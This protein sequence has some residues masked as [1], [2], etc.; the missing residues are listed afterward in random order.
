MGNALQIARGLFYKLPVSPLSERN[1]FF[2][3]YIMLFESRFMMTALLVMG[4]REM[5][6]NFIRTL[7]ITTEKNEKHWSYL[8]KI[9]SYLEAAIW[10]KPYFLLC[11]CL[12]EW[13]FGRIC[14]LSGSRWN[15]R[16]VLKRNQPF[17]QHISSYLKCYSWDAKKAC[18][19]QC[20]WGV[21]PLK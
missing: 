19:P 2:R 21:N 5:Q 12:L 1:M 16:L 8:W 13:D 11:P 4:W 20:K 3:M 6:W 7:K 10:M 9:E 18:L 14:R 15:I 17:L